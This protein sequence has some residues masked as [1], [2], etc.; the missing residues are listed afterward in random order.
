MK[1]NLFTLVA[2]LAAI[3]TSGC[4]T[5]YQAP[6]SVPTATLAFVTPLRPVVVQSFTDTQCTHGNNGVRLAYIDPVYA[7]G[8][9]A[10]PVKVEAEREIVLTMKRIAIGVGSGALGAALGGG[11]GE[12]AVT[13]KFFPKTGEA[14]ELHFTGT[15]IKDCK[16]DVFRVLSTRTDGQTLVADSTAQNAEKTCYSI[17]N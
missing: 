8:R 5:Y 2:A 3:S 13:T 11:G 6:V 15:T 16:V 14:Y 4:I 7:S 1:K 12:C 17:N 10:G 9:H